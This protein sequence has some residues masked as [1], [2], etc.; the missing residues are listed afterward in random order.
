[1]TSHKEHS[2]SFISFL[3]KLSGS[4]D[5][6]GPEKTGNIHQNK[7]LKEVDPPSPAK[8]PKKK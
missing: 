2:N 8:K 7:L 6:S 1:M 3:R 4:A 5:T